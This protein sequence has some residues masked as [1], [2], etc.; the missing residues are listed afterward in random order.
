MT[1]DDDV[2]NEFN[3]QAAAGAAGAHAMTPL[4]LIVRNARVA[5]AADVFDA[6]I[7]IAGGRIVYLGQGGQG[8]PAAAREIDAASTPTATSTS[9][10]RR[11]CAWPTTSSPA[12][13]RRPAAARRR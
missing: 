5:T 7:G 3:H 13:A 4:D 10:W 12:R 11:R 6:D 9:R 2:D 8:L 1:V